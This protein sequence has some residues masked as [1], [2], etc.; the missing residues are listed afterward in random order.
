MNDMHHKR[1]LP[2]ERHTTRN[3]P[4]IWALRR[5][6]D[7]SYSWAV[8]DAEAK[9]GGH[10]SMPRH[11]INQ[12]RTLIQ[13]EPRPLVM[14]VVAGT[15]QGQPEHLLLDWLSQAS[16]QAAVEAAAIWRDAYRAPTSASHEVFTRLDCEPLPLV[17]TSTD[18]GAVVRGCLAGLIVA[19]DAGI[20][21][22]RDVIVDE[23]R[24]VD[25]PHDQRIG[26]RLDICEKLVWPYAAAGRTL[27]SIDR[28]KEIGK[29]TA[30]TLD[31]QHPKITPLGKPLAERGSAQLALAH[32][33][34]AGDVHPVHH[35]SVRQQLL[36]ALITGCDQL[37]A[38]QERKTVAAGYVSCLTL[39][40]RQQHDASMVLGR[41]AAAAQTLSTTL[42]S[43]RAAVLTP[44]CRAMPAEDQALVVERMVAE[45]PMDAAVMLALARFG[46][47]PPSRS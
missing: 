28:F 1:S 18:E 14:A 41:A 23:L 26:R 3:Q 6:N 8:N 10:S 29:A 17:Q 13:N 34:V 12:W 39:T 46:A 24:T 20:D 19:A 42:V 2:I 22:A 35:A 30:R 45:Q 27:M 43:R 38:D 16:P 15:T 36:Q 33:A 9:D 11:E 37:S 5:G 47:R 44:L 7:S 40:P 25:I 21:S 4:A 31:V 32:L